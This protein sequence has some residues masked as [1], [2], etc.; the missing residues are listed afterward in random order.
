MLTTKMP[1]KL[2]PGTGIDTF[3]MQSEMNSEGNHDDD[4][5]NGNDT[6]ALQQKQSY[7]DV[8]DSCVEIRLHNDPDGHHG[9]EEALCLAAD[10]ECKLLT[11][12][13]MSL[14][15]LLFPAL[16]LLDYVLV[17]DMYIGHCSNELAHA[18]QPLLETFLAKFPRRVSTWA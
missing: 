12:D 4:S 3:D 16:P 13:A 11:M 10:T 7:L 5:A 2:T 6:A 9:W 18:W 14:S 8:G 15:H 1:V 17:L